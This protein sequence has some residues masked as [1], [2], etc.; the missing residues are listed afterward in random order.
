MHCTE[1]EV[2]KTVALT[3]LKKKKKK[4]FKE[5]TGGTGGEP[6]K[7]YSSM[8][9]IKKSWIPDRTKTIVLW[10]FFVLVV[11]LSIKTAWH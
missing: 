1:S 8:E 3:S 6:K 10:V 7:S 4:S 9:Y 2:H 11:F 5:E